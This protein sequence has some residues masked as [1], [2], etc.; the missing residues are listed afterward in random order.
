[1]LILSYLCMPQTFAPFR[2]W[3]CLLML[4]SLVNA[5]PYWRVN[6]RKSL[7]PLATLVFL[8]TGT[9]FQARQSPPNIPRHNDGLYI[10]IYNSS[11]CLGIFGGDCLAWNKPIKKD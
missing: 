3:Q 6:L 9:L 5:Q 4:F 8:N 10:Y 1:M 11:L 7:M 2:A